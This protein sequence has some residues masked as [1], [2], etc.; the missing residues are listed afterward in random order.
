[1]PHCREAGIIEEEDN[2][3]SSLQIK[4][5][6]RIRTAATTATTAKKANEQNKAEQSK[7]MLN[8]MNMST[9]NCI[10]ATTTTT[11]RTTTTATAASAANSRSSRQNSNS[12]N[13]NNNNN[14][15]NSNQNDQLPAQLSSRIIH[16]RNGAL[17][18]VIVQLDGRH[19]DPVEAYRGIPYASPPVGNLRFMPPVSAAM[20]SG[21]KKADRTIVVAYVHKSQDIA[22]IS[23]KSFP[24]SNIRHHSHTTVQKHVKYNHNNGFESLKAFT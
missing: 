23:T 16:T 2:S 20:W 12:N 7:I 19:L 18:G 8:K 17:S 22:V 9:E 10:A 4:D 6:I 1:M 21:V 5:K 3:I 24:L 14:N 15:N 13:N 11:R